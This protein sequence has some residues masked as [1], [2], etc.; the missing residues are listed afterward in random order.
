MPFT[1]AFYSWHLSHVDTPPVH[2]IRTIVF[3]RKK[4]RKEASKV[5]ISTAPRLA[6][7]MVNPGWGRGLC[8]LWAGGCRPPAPQAPSPP[9]TAASGAPAGGPPKPG[10]PR[11]AA[12]LLFPLSW[13]LAEA[14]LFLGKTLSVKDVVA[15]GLHPQT[16]AWTW[17]E[18][19][20]IS[21][22]LWA[23]IPTPCH[24]QVSIQGP[25]GSGNSL[26]WCVEGM[27][28]HGHV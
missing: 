17:F 12:P 3:K 28:S 22:Y 13:L 11:L 25:V 2:K 21:L 1:N 18:L 15:S 14:P 19:G 20:K 6:R 24:S 8:P 5:C 23:P 26:T 9:D 16:M 7:K 4:R 27:G 10:L